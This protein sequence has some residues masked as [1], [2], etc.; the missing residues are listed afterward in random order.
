MSCA[1]WEFVI[2]VRWSGLWLLTALPQVRRFP[3]SESSLVPGDCP[4][5]RIVAFFGSCL[6]LFASALGALFR[7]PGGA[8]LAPPESLGLLMGSLVGI[9]LLLVLPAWL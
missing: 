7:G 6:I 4:M 1:W 5:P 2:G 3:V 9:V 8:S